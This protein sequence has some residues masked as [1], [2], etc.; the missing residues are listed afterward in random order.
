MGI[1]KSN[2]CPSIIYHMDTS[3]PPT[4]ARSGGELLSPKAIPPLRPLSKVG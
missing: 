1:H 4:G 2:V 3:L